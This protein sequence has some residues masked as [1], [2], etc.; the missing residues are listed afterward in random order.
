MNALN[1]QIIETTEA[2]RHNGQC[3][4]G[5]WVTLDEMIENGLADAA[6]A[7]AD[8]IAEAISRDMRREPHADGNTDES[9]QVNVGGETWIYRR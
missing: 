7:I 6:N 5:E 1:S 2:R 4:Y 3:A 9:G 8:E